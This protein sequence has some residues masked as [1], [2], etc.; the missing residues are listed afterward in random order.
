MLRE[1]SLPREVL[2]YERAALSNGCSKNQASEEA[3][4]ALVAYRP[5]Y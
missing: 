1:F 2:I 5:G 3:P 4:T